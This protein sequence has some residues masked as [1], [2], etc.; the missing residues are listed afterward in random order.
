MC[1]GEIFNIIII[2]WRTTREREKFTKNYRSTSRWKEGIKKSICPV[3]TWSLVMQMYLEY[4]S[5]V[6]DILS[7]FAY[8]NPLLIYRWLWRY[9]FFLKWICPRYLGVYVVLKGVIWFEM[10]WKGA[11]YGSKILPTLGR[12]R[13]WKKGISNTWIIL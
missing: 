5:K 11:Q 7:L 1:G 2:I 4:P 9:L 8:E 13:G 12:G 3:L 6:W 10:F